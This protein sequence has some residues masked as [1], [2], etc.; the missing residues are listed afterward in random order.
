MEVNLCERVDD[1]RH[2]PFHLLNYLITI[3]SEGIIK[4]QGGKAWTIGRVRNYLDVHLGQIVYDKDGVVDWYIILVEMPQ[5]GFEECWPLPTES[6][7]E[8]P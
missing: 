2:S 5:T 3:P 8:L 1:L 4:S 6:L 7:P